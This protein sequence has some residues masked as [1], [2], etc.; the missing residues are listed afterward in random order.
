MKTL[1]IPLIQYKNSCFLYS[2]RQEYLFYHFVGFKIGLSRK[3][4][5]IT[6]FV[7]SHPYTNYRF[8]Y[9]NLLKIIFGGK[10]CEI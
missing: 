10:P 8:V 7:L 2:N 4:G 3:T 1:E 5:E 6:G 9:D